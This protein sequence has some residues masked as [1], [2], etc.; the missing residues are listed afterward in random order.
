MSK[1][2]FPEAQE[3]ADADAV[4]QAAGWADTLVSRVYRGPGDTIEA[5]HYRAE[6][7]FGIPAQTFWALR[8]RR[9]KD[10]LVSVWLRL[11]QAYEAE[12]E[13]QEAKLRHELEI[14][15]ALSPTPARLAL[16]REVEAV[17]RP[18]VGMAASEPDVDG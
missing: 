11:K 10:M 5:A 8:Y 9:P 18:A 15:K 16:V 7:R 1:N 2:D 13:R 12:V 6:Q 3:V 4:D 14:T 17:L